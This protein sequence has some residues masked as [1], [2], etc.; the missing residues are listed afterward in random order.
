VTYKISNN[1]RGT[2]ASGI[3]DAVTTIP[4][5]SGHGARFPSLGANEIT[6]VTLTDA[7]KNIEVVKVTGRTGDNLTVERGA[8]E[9]TPRAWVAGD[10]VYLSFCRA[11]FEAA[12]DDAVAAA[13]AAALM[14]PGVMLDY[15]GAGAVPAGYL[16]CDGS[17]VSQATYPALFAAIGT[18]WDTG[19]EGGGNFRLPDTRRRVSM[20]KGGTAVSGPANTVGA[21]G[22]AETHAL[23]TGELAAHTHTGPSHTHS[24]SATTS[25]D[26]AHTHNTT[27]GPQIG[28]TT[29]AIEIE[30]GSP[31]GNLQT[32]SN[33]AHTHTVA[34]TTGAEGTGATGSAGSGTAHNNVQPA[35]VVAKIIK[36]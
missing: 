7:S 4:L 6:F 3:D 19:G 22:G 11:A 15:A 16:L 31:T 33:G 12:M 14:P 24:F 27:T 17:V 28:S 20:G 25:S 2:L 13:L 9:T 23:T 8:D 5:S 36:T 32:S 34:G 21:V 30:D 26:G 29:V 18:T 35:Y 1:A 10:T